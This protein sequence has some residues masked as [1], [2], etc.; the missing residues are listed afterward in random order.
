MNSRVSTFKWRELFPLGEGGMGVTYL[1]CAKG[2]GGFERLIAIKRLHEHLQQDAE[3]KTRLLCEAELAG[4]VQHANVV[5]VQHV[6]QDDRG[7]FLVLDY[8]DGGSLSHLMKTCRPERLP[9]SIVLRVITDCL[10][11]LQAIHTATNHRGDS[12]QIL[13]RDI[14]PDNV[15]IGLDGVARLTDFGIARANNHPS[16]TAPTQLVG[17]LTYMAPEYIDKRTLGPPLD[18][19]SLG[20]ML[21]ILLAGHSPWKGLEDAQLLARLLTEGVPELPGSLPVG[22][23]LRHI[24]RRACAKE[25]ADRYQSASAMSRAIGSFASRGRIASHEDVA[26]FVQRKLDP[27]TSERRLKAAQMLKLDSIPP[28]RDEI[29]AIEIQPQTSGTWKRARQSDEVPTTPYERLQASTAEYR[30]EDRDSLVRSSRDELEA[31]TATS[32]DAVLDEPFA[33]VC[34]TLRSRRSGV[35]SIAMWAGLSGIASAAIGLG[36]TSTALGP[37]ANG[38]A[39]L[40]ATQPAAPSFSSRTLLEEG[41]PNPPLLAPVPDQ[42]PTA[43]PQASNPRPVEE[44]ARPPKSERP[45]KIR[46]TQPSRPTAVRTPLA[47]AAPRDLMPPRQV[48]HHGSPPAAGGIVLRNPYRHADTS[49]RK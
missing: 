5:G 15:L 32:R 16:L 11:G 43:P 48:E 19:Y 12:L 24:V 9:Q 28:A 39:P 17:K 37:E 8:V 14:S 21:W 34:S 22:D 31:T 23:D 30:K 4:C 40:P 1:G 3:A 10:A 25:P 26:L 42:A 13:H 7:A 46:Q 29:P 35:W 41:P 47:P 6:D 18:V 36:L 2:V 20:V 33:E 44:S 49:P 27:T 38:E 45:T